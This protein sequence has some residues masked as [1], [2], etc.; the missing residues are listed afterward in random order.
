MPNF[1][2]SHP[3][4]LALLR[5]W[6]GKRGVR[7]LPS[8]RD[9]DPVEIG[10]ELLP[11]L[12][13]ADLLDRGTRVRFRLVGTAVVKRLGA[14]PTGRYLERELRGPWFDHWGSL[15]RLVYAER[16]P[17]FAE[18]ELTWG[19]GRRLRVSNLLLPLSQDG[20]D[21]AIALSG[22]AFASEEM[23]PPSLRALA[24]TGAHQE[25]R[26]VVLRDVAEPEEKPSGRQ[27]A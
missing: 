8:R 16:A 2:L 10:P 19:R 13:L 26:R 3:H 23:F 21:P 6:L 17:V 20:P 15:H 9:I 27:V 5:Y 12:V 14:D 1:P 25:L 18:S 11:S 7:A 24:E 4:L 22:L